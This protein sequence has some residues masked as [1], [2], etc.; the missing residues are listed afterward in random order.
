MNRI[1]TLQQ[2]VLKTIDE[3]KDV[4]RSGSP[5]LD[6]ERIHMVSCAK[7]GYMLA[8][9]RGLDPD[10]SACACAVHDFGRILTG[11]QEN[12][13]PAGA[14]PVQLFLRDTAL[15]SEDEIIMI[16]RAVENHSKKGEVGT[17]LE[18]LVKE[19]DLM[20]YA[21]YGQVFKRQEQIDR[22]HRLSKGHK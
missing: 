19:A 5:P 10:L 13:G 16:S 11:S 3:H 14:M 18:E 7:V 21:S 2:A 20:D 8:M 15:F 12:H 1:F 4:D 17:P 22:F 6:W 9:E